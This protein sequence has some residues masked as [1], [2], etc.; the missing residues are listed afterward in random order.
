MSYSNTESG[1]QEAIL[2]VRNLGWEGEG[3]GGGDAP[4]ER[5]CAV[6][7]VRWYAVRTRYRGRILGR[8]WDKS[9]KSFP[10]CYSQSPLQTDFIPPPPSLEQKW[11]KT[12]L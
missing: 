8:N 12:R 11:F 5:G 10:F 4:E 3:G 7:A 1:N 2:I 6:S 9:L